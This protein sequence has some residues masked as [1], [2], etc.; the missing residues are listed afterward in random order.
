MESA[1]LPR[2]ITWTIVFAFVALAGITFIPSPAATIDTVRTYFAEA[3]IERGVHYSFERRLLM[4]GSTLVQLGV[5]LAFAGR[6]GERVTERCR[7]LARGWWLP[8]LLLVGGFY[9]VLLCYIQ[10]PFDL[11]RFVLQR[12]WGLTTRSLAEWLEEYRLALALSAVIEGVVLVG[13]YLLMRWLPRWWWLAAAAGSV[14]LAI[15]FAFLLP[16]VIAPLFNTFTPIGETKWVEW[17]QPLRKLIAKAEVPV[18]EV[19]IMNASKQST[20]TNAYFTGFGATRRIVLYDNLLDKHTLPE[21]ESILA[22]EIG[23]WK[24]DHIVQ[25]I[26]LGGIGAL[27]G[28]FLLARILK[29]AEKP[30]GL[31]GPS[32]PAG[33]PIVLLAAYLGSWLA[34]P[35]ANAVSRHF[36][37]QADMMALELGRQPDVFIA[38]ERKLAID[39]ISNVAPAPWNV[40]LFNTHPPA[41]ERIQM[42]EA[43]KRAH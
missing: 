35:L 4:W 3:D 11:T 21:V 13:L 8:T 9:F 16:M 40:W 42:A 30:W 20:H 7:R 31:Q 36:E 24:H 2:G 29:W 41:L 1:R 6:W 14:A 5:L 15:T 10:W 28:F 19:L 33:L 38:A 32:D 26:A 22:H 43:W 12:D 27:V 23:H 18:D 37:R 34:T 17:E 39:N 25:G